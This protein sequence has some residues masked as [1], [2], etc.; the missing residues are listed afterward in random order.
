M[1]CALAEALKD[2]P[3]GQEPEAVVVLE[4]ETVLVVLVERV[5]ALELEAAVLSDVVV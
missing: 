4:P 3:I 1:R 2:R 5:V